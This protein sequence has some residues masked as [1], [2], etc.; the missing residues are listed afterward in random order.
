MAD[1][2]KPRH[3]TLFMCGDVMTGRGIDQVLPHPGNPVIHEWYMRS[4]GGYVDLAEEVNGPIPKPVDF[5]YIWGDALDEFGRMKPDVRIINLETAV[6]TSEDY[7]DKGINYRMSPANIPAMTAAGIDVCV[8]ANNHV[9]DWGE[10]GLAET[11]E[12]LKEAGLKTA[13]AGKTLKDAAAPAVVDLSG[14]G[15]VI[16]FSFGSPTSGIPR[17][18]AATGTRP[19]VNLLQYLSR[20]TV[21]LIEGQVTKIKHPGDVVVFSVHWGGNWDYEIPREHVEFAHR[22]IDEAG[23][24]VVHGH[25]SHHVKGIEVYRGKLV[26]YGCGDL[27]TD[28]EGISGYEAFRSD[29]GLMYFAAIDPSTGKLLRLGMTPTQ[30]KRFRITRASRKDALWLR[31]LLD[32]EGGRFGTGAAIN[33]DNT[34][35][36]QWA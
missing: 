15:R 1:P 24:D 25:S 11:V 9:L 14:K 17:S 2:E 35:E 13:G 27:L 10:K 33:E 23:I 6:T 36:I 30:M 19:G 22:I 31:D 18:W 3:I 28:Y 20:D 29:L 5:S 8:L 32:R 4:A 34:I 16:V 12:T 21:P 26:L 7:S